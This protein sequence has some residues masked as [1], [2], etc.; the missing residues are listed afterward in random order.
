[1]QDG[2]IGVGRAG[3]HVARVL[4]VSR[5]VDDDEA[6]PRRLEIAPSDVDGDALLA[7]A[8]EPVEQ[9]AEIDAL[10][11]DAAVMRGKRYGRALVLGDPGGVPQHPADQRRFSVTRRAASKQLE[12]RGPLRGLGRGSARSD[13]A[14]LDRL[15]QLRYG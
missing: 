8:L 5:R 11:V 13:A 6:A 4:L 3:R 7:L 12:Q 9:E 2:D 1:E 14:R 15:F 10:A